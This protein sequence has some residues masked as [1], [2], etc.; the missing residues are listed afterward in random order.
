MKNVFVLSWQLASTL[1]CGSAEE[2]MPIIQDA[3]LNLDFSTIDAVALASLR[4]EDPAPPHSPVAELPVPSTASRVGEELIR[5]CVTM[6]KITK[7]QQ[8]LDRDKECQK[9][10]L[11]LLPYFF[12]KKE[13]ANSNTNGTNKKACLNSIKLN[14]LKTLVFSKFPVA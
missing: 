6:R 5:T 11:R 4:E 1:D 14:S 3:P 7:V 12:T 10:A 9:C 2:I 8:A 13:L